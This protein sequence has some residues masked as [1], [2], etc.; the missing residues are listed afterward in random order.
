MYR[1]AAALALILSS[2]V[3]ADSSQ[4]TSFSSS[5]LLN[6]RLPGLGTTMPEVHTQP[7]PKF[8]ADAA[9]SG[10]REVSE[11][12]VVVGGAGTVLAVRVPKPLQSEFGFDEA[13]VEAVKRWKFRPA[14][15][16]TSPVPALVFVQVTFEA[17]A[18]RKPAVSA[19]ILDV[20]TRPEIASDHFNDPDVFR[21]ATHGVQPPTIIRRV[22]PLYTSSAMRAKIQGDVEIDAVIDAHGVVESARVVR[23]LD[24][25]FGLD[26]QALH[27]GSYWL[28]K[29][30]MQDGRAVPT[31]VTFILSFRLH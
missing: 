27:A 8:P 9:K 21:P 5:E 3:S 11:L 31:R 23:S 30:A 26:A 1:T 22:S 10:V 16:G 7:L 12:E 17:S 25:R 14:V 18:A 24:D 19:A 15:S 29:P 13:A 4:G 28:F 6:V 2:A 20:P